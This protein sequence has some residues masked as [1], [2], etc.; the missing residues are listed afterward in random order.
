MPLFA[1]KRVRIYPHADEPGQ[2]AARQWGD[3][4]RAAGA[5]VDAFDLSG[6]RKADGNAVKDL[7]DCCLIHPEDAADLEGLLP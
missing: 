1:G 4:L 3:Q 6:L 2:K 5:E 7:N